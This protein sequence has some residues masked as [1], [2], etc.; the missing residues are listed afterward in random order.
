MGYTS[1]NSHVRVDFFRQEGKQGRLKWYTT[2]EVVMSDY[3]YTNSSIYDAFSDALLAHL[4]GRLVDMVAVCLKPHHQ[5]SHPIAM[6][7]GER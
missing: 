2:E 7:Y 1:S 3:H 5:H 4:G 6:V